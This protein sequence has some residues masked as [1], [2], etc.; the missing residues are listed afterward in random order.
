[1]CC[2]CAVCVLC[3]CVLTTVCVCAAATTAGEA[4]EG[5]KKIEEVDGREE[6]QKGEGGKLF[7]FVVLC[8]GVLCV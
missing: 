1:M 6:E 4:S 7:G 2:A 8:C 3:V 5:E